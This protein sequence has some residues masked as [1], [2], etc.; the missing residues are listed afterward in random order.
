MELIFK[1]ASLG[2]LVVSFLT[3]FILLLAGK[4]AGSGRFVAFCKNVSEFTASVDSINDGNLQQFEAACLTEH[5]PEA[6]KQG[7]N[8]FKSARFGY[9]S[10]YFD[11]TACMVGLD[12]KRHKKTAVIIL[13]ILYV[14]A[15]ALSAGSVF[16]A[17]NNVDIIMSISSVVVI[18]WFIIFCIKGNS[19]AKAKAA[20]DT[21]LE[22][23]DVSVQMQ[24]YENYQMDSSGLDAVVEAI[25]KIIFDEENK[26]IPSKKDQIVHSEDFDMD[27]I[28]SEILPD[29]EIQPTEIAL[30]EDE[31][32]LSEDDSALNEDGAVS[33]GYLPKE[34]EYI[35]PYAAPAIYQ[36][37]E[38]VEPAPVK[39][40]ID[41]NKFNGVLN[42]I[43][44]GQYSKETLLKVAKLMI[45]AFGKFTE[46][47]QRAE[48]KNSIRR[49]I[50]AYQNA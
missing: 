20:F 46:P 6:V 10:E 19:S 12:K 50:K 43:V 11:K 37:E 31:S 42:Q 5:A 47:E 49:L 45:V 3:F 16:I 24:K 32:A 13:I 40:P 44:D 35:N 15:I 14:L 41:F 2:L 22:D 17:K 34:E 18:P 21:M 27:D 39:K 33:Y 4:R 8:T 29:E 26:P 23:L 30:N 1:Y 48:L 7:W 25:N 28:K 36:Q 38:I 9:P